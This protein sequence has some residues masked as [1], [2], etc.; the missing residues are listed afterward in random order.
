M[1]T[2]NE[3]EKS[4]IKYLESL[5]AKVKHEEETYGTDNNR[6]LNKYIDEMLACKCMAESIIGLPINCQLDGKVSIGF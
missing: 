2:L 1:R 6:M 3:T 5:M 4:M